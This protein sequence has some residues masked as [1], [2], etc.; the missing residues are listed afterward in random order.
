MKGL[1]SCLSLD[2]H[3]TT[4]FIDESKQHLRSTLHSH[5][6]HH[7]IMMMEDN[8]AHDHAIG[9]ANASVTDERTGTASARGDSDSDDGDFDPSNPDNDQSMI[10]VDTDN[11]DIEDDKDDVG[12][13]LTSKSDEEHS[14][15]AQLRRN[16][17]DLCVKKRMSI[18]C[19][20]SSK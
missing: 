2:C 10:I 4:P 9:T 11:S 19:T 8:C 14:P 6:S 16:S 13:E 18:S 12:D 5:Q 7:T 20:N 1:S 17:S 15:P 3:R